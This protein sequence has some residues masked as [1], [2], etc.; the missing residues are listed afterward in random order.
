MMQSLILESGIRATLVAFLTYAILFVL[1]IKSPRVRHSVWTGVVVVMLI[2]PVWTAWGP[3][4]SLPIVRPV[5]VAIAM[6]QPIVAAASEANLVVKSA[7]STIQF[8][9][10]ML[11]VAIYLVGLA[12]LLARLMI[13]S[14]EHTSE[15]QS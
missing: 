11:G 12:V 7:D 9:W 8:N 4:A 14:E 2:L 5:P 6:K 15:L 3:K 1:H 13:R 10:P